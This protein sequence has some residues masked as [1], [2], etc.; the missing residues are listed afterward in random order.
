MKNK[1]SA[2]SLVELSIVIMIIGILLVGITQASRLVAQS[3]LKTARS[4]TQSSPVASI[5]GLWAWYESTSEASFTTAQTDDSSQIGTWYDINPQSTQNNKF[6]LTRTA[7]SAVIY[8]ATAINGLP[9]VNFAT[10]ASTVSLTNSNFIPVTGN[11]FSFFIVL[12]SAEGMVG[13]A[14]RV[15]FKNGADNTGFGYRTASGPVRNVLVGAS[16]LAPSSGSVPAKSVEI[17]SSVGTSGAA[18]E[19]WLNGAAVA[20]GS[21]TAVAGVTP[22]GALYVGGSATAS[23]AW[24]GYI[25]EVIIF[26]GVLKDADRQDVEKYLGKKWGIVVSTAS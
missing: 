23:T 26:E 6:D 2:F 18:V 3:K 13:A 12:Q 7:S 20:L 14:T 4:V 24:L 19:L 11:N 21:A 5:P 1:T 10:G 9:A 8:T 15:A 22:T 16:T 25:G 17:I